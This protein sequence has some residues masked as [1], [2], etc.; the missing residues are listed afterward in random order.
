[1]V[2]RLIYAFS[3]PFR[4]VSE[5][6]LS[7]MLTSQMNGPIVFLSDSRSPSTW[8]KFVDMEHNKKT[9]HM[10]RIVRIRQEDLEEEDEKPT[11]SFRKMLISFFGGKVGKRDRGKTRTTTGKGPD[12]YNIYDR[13][14]DFSNN[15]GWSIALDED[16]YEPLKHDDFGVYLVNLT[17]VTQIRVPN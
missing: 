5:S 1:M 3:S 10:R 13:K 4:Q 6:E 8:S 12:A 2:K 17:A 9:A 7:E 11:W 15:Y 16:D 14:P